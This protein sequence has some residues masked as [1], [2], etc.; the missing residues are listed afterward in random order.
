MADNESEQRWAVERARP[1]SGPVAGRARQGMFGVRGTG[2]T[3]GY[4]G[5]RLPAYVPP[6]AER[7]Y[8]G[9]FDEVADALLAA[10]GERGL[11]ADTVQQVTVDRGEITFYVRTDQLLEV[12]RALRDDPAL[13]FELCSSVSGVDYGP[14]VPQRLHSVCHLTSMT[15]RR[16][17]RVEVAVD[18]E[19]PH[20]PS[21]VE[22]YPT[23]DFQ[24]RETWDMFGIVYDG[25][26]AL[27]RILM[28]DDWDGH[29]QR[30]DYPLGGIPVEY[31]GAEIPP[32][33]QRRAYS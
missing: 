27:T 7:P 5:L 1:Q 6:A 4:G 3:S 33:D 15:Y 22:V 14:E 2:D 8:G 16:R 30:K 9:W 12:C 10:L 32:P 31:K 23:A 26:P 11:P 24:E 20:V 19:D 18:V 25:H 29:P 17:I 28:P 21:V 13:R